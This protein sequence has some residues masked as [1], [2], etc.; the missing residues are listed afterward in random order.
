MIHQYLHMTIRYMLL[1]HIYCYLIERDHSISWLGLRNHN[2]VW[3]W[4]ALCASLVYSNAFHFGFMCTEWHD[5]VVLIMQ[6]EKSTYQVLK[7]IHPLIRP[8]Y[9]LPLFAPYLRIVLERFEHQVLKQLFINMIIVNNNSV[10]YRAKHQLK[11]HVSSTDAFWYQ[12]WA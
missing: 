4:Y 1:Q 12:R 7:L 8:L 5:F 11:N 9:S 3:N 6:C 10:I 2:L